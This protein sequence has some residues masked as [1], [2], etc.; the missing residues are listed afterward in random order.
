M[1]S[2][3][4]GFQLESRQPQ[5]C[6]EESTLFRSDCIDSE[7]VTDSEP[8]KTIGESFPSHETGKSAANVTFNRNSRDDQVCFWVFSRK[9]VNNKNKWRRILFDERKICNGV[10]WK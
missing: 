6:S 9:G 7:S 4:E 8:A 2:L 10:G 5:L 1:R 3:S